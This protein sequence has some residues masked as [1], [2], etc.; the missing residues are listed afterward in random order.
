[1][2]IA[3]D[4]LAHQFGD[5][6]DEVVVE[7]AGDDGPRRRGAVLTGVDERRG[8]RALDGGVEIGVVEH[9]ERR[10]AAEFEL[11]AMPVLGGR[12]HH[13]AP[14]GRRPGERHQVDVAVSGQC[15][16][17][18]AAGPGDDVEHAG[19]QAGLAGEPRQRERRQRRHLGGL[20]HHRAA[21]GQRRNDLPYGHLQRIVPRRDGR[22]DADGLTPDAGGV[23]GRVFGGGLP[24]EVPCRAREEVDVVHA[25]GDVEIGC[26]PDRLTRLA[27]FLGDQRFGVFA[28]ELGQLGQ[29]GGTLRRR[30][31]RPFRQ[32]PSRG[33]HGDVDVLRRRQ[34]AVGNHVPRRRIDDLMHSAAGAHLGAV[35]PAARD[36][37]DFYASRPPEVELRI[38]P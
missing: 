34:R 6:R 22:D 1:M 4:D 13:L 26:E 28:G 11:G 23:V 2:R 10:L 33:G 35:D 17:D 7:V 9:Q 37:H 31:S 16:A 30:R 20:D 36:R 19:G 27:D 21:G 14:H 12:G 32:R 38:P 3:D 29:H 8:D 25:A 15:R 5:T 24:L 18:V